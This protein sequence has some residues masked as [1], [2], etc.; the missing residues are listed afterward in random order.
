MTSSHIRL[1]KPSLGFF[2]LQKALIVHPSPY[3]CLVFD[4]LIW[5]HYVSFW[6]LVAV[7]VHILN[8]THDY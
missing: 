7:L 1:Q 2:L 5:K 4:L 6:D 3:D 8:Q